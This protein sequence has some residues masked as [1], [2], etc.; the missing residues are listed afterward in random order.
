M[1]ASLSALKSIHQA[2]GY[3]GQVDD[4]YR[5]TEMAPTQWSGVGAQMM[6]LHGE[7]DQQEFTALLKGHLPN[8]EQLGRA[9]GH[10]GIDHRPGWDM[11]FSAPKSVSI[12]ALVGDDERLIHSHEKSVAAALHFL[13]KNG[14]AHQRHGDT[15]QASDNLLIAQFRHDTSREQQPQLHSHC[16]IL[17]MTQ[18]TAGRWRS[19]ESRPL[20][21]LH[22]EA[23]LVYRSELARHCRELGYDLHAS[24]VGKEPGFEIKGVSAS[25]IEHWSARS[26][27][28]EAALAERGQTRQ[29]ATAATKE[30]A[31]LD[32]RSHKGNVDHQDLR[33]LWRGE[34][35]QHDQILVERANQARVTIITSSMI[36]DMSRQSALEAVAYASEKLVERNSRFSEHELLTE[37]RKVAFGKANDHDLRSAIVSAL[38]RGNLIARQTRGY[39]PIQGKK[40]IMAGFTTPRAIAT[41]RSL[42]ASAQRL[43]GNATPICRNSAAHHAIAALEKKTGQPFNP[44]QKT[45]TIGVLTSTD[46]L[47]LIQGYAGTAKTTSVLVATAAEL[48]RQGKLV[49]ALAPT[50]SA[51]KTLGDALG[52][53]GMTVARHLSMLERT[54]SNTIKEAW[55]VDEASLL[56][57]RDMAR[58]LNHAEKQQAR[59]ILVGDVKQLG[60][61]EAGAAFRQLQDQAKIKSHVLDQIVRQRNISARDVVHASIRGN[62]QEALAHIDR[63]GVVQEHPHRDSR[64]NALVNDYMAQSPEQRLNSLVVALGRDDVYVINQAIRSSMKAR[65][66]LSGASVQINALFPK[67]LT[68]TEARRAEAYQIGDIIRFARNY[69]NLGI[70]NSD[71]AKITA[72]DADANRITVEMSDGRPVAFNP[73]SHAKTEVFEQAV[74]TLQVGDRIRFTRNDHDQSRTNGQILTIERIEDHRIYARDAEE[75]HQTLNTQLACDR[76]IEHAYCATTYAAQGQT[77]DRVFI[78]ME[79]F[80]TNLANQQSFYVAVS[81]AKD[82]VRIYTDHRDKLISQIERESGEKSLALES[83]TSINVRRERG[84]IEL[85]NH[86]D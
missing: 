22:K 33:E 79:S 68:R 8:G 56:S 75:N 37:A 78:H 66:E 28:I 47:N 76:H 11:T 25:L 39:D 24:R 19:L 52:A 50:A 38:D 63:A 15:P 42:L 12:M 36:Q 1:V 30:H 4:Y 23:G 74:R 59:V 14:A 81:R 43:L 72:V 18:D 69:V 71:Y 13:E 70:G 84:P 65:G 44:S 3:Y 16:V 77:S 48:S 58:L 85:G 6:G 64:I 2:A 34:A 20:Y 61:V 49:K 5:E 17:N 60:S 40:E 10:G 7:V 55:I 35:G 29:T 9:D 86:I 53:T 62:A 73:R 82:E 54:T 57:A 80:R 41:E 21:R 31:A 26:R 46:H 45:A 67:D 32:S 27:Q 83:A 51:A